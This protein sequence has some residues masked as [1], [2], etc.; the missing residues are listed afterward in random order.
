LP[1]NHKNQINH[2][3]IKVQTDGNES[4]RI[5][6]KYRLKINY[7][8]KNKKIMS[9]NKSK[10]QQVISPVQYIRTK[11]RNLP[12][13]ECYINENWQQMGL[14]SVIVAR[15]HKSGCYTI[16]VYLVDIFCLGVK[17]SMYKFN[18]SHNELDEF[19]E[20]LNYVSIS[21]N[22]AHNIVYGA[23]AYAEDLGIAPHKDFSLTQ[24]ILEEDTDDIPLIE[25][26]FG[27]NGKPFLV[28][29]NMLE[30]NKYRSTLERS[31]NGD[32]HFSV[33][34]NDFDENEYEDDDDDDYNTEESDP[35]P[36]TQYNYQYPEYPK[37]LKLTHTELNYL[38]LAENNDRLSEETIRQILSL[39][40][41]SLIN[42]LKHCILY[43]IGQFNA[44][45]QLVEDNVYGT[46]T[47]CLLLLGELRAT[48]SLDA[49][50]EIMRQ[51]EEFLDFYF[52]DYAERFLVPA[53]YYIADSQLNTLF[54]YIKEPGLDT[55]FRYNIFPTIVLIA[56]Q[57][58][59]RRA[60][61]IKWF[62]DVLDFYY[63]KRADT[64]YCDANLAGLIMS[65]L[66]D[67]EAAELLPKI[68][69]LFDANMVDK[70]YN[71][72]YD[73]IETEICVQNFHRSNDLK[74]L[75]IYEA[76]DE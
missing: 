2:T 41:E 37:E 45:G 39:P 44:N 47:H 64:S 66:L 46:L 28:A 3:K 29:H 8:H 53:L 58:P 36:I 23:L 71:G 30:L 48:E 1:I 10:N 16:G 20:N 51:N 63:E 32:F 11:A 62:G 68:K 65:N 17:D 75:N 25:Y 22:E 9:K 13:A 4:R 19:M 76:Y 35:F 56:Q 42:D 52:G 59:E 24:Y 38:F 15:V 12:I 5:I 26:E 55:F 74:L 70:S 43:T 67:L 27:K 54:A 7:Y 6:K 14:A 72:D 60:E 33:A 57:Q 73:D 49:V 50:L 18:V 69:K 40:R 21:Y 31:T 34:G 61:V